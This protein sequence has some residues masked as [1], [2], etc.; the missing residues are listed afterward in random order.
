MLLDEPSSALDTT[1]REVLIE[2][3][4]GAM[5]R[6]RGVFL[7]THDERGYNAIADECFELEDGQIRKL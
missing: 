4:K 2:E 5:L 3:L 7:V 1:N 6:D